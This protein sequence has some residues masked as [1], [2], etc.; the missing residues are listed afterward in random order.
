MKLSLPSVNIVT[1]TTEKGAE[2]Y[3]RTSQNNYHNN[4]SY[5]QRGGRGNGRS[6]SGGRGNRNKPQCQ[7]CTKLRHNVASFDILQDQIH[8]ITHQTHIILHTLI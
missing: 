5:N 8:Q 6:N 4:H 7:I 2:S 3:I 1:Q